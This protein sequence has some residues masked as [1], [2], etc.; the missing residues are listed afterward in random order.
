[1]SEVSERAVVGHLTFDRRFSQGAKALKPFGKRL[2][3]PQARIQAV[4][5]D[6]SMA[7]ISAAQTPLPNAAIM[8]DYRKRATNW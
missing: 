5:M 8:Y 3:S 2:K 4:A 1:M 6:M 7:H